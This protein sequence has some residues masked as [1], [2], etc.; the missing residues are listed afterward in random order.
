MT[1]LALGVSAISVIRLD[2][3]GLLASVAA[4]E[5]DDN[6]SSFQTG[7]GGNDRDKQYMSVPR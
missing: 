3:D 7:F 6:L 2:N 5:Q 1:K 4:R